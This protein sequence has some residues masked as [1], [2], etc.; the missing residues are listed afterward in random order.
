MERL[1]LEYLRPQSAR[2]YNFYSIPKLLI[3]HPG[4][5]EL[6]YGAKLLYGLILNRASLSAEH[7]EEFTDCQGRLYI[8]YTVEQVME[9]I[10]CARATA[11]KL[12]K[13]LTEIGLIE[14]KRQGQGK[15]TLIY[16]KDFASVNLNAEA[17]APAT[18]GEEEKSP[19]DQFPNDS[20]E[21]RREA[22][23]N[24]RSSNVE[25]Q[26]VQDV[27]FKKFKSY[28]SRSSSSRLLE[29]QDL[30][31]SYNDLND[32]DLSELKSIYLSAGTEVDMM[33]EDGLEAL[34]QNVEEQLEYPVLSVEYGEERAKE[35]VRLVVEVLCCEGEV[36]VGKGRYPPVLVRK[37]MKQLTCEHVRYALDSMAAGDKPVRNPRGYL[38]ASL[39]NAPVSWD[40]AETIR[41]EQGLRRWAG[42]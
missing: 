18:N 9:D 36:Q 32:L 38:L 33:D 3:D 31:S 37:R 28:T 8:V 4:F 39:F 16:V 41:A 21:N 12:L 26:E 27:D 19:E 15:P 17:A 5:D 23:E 35:I 10:R 7:S 24:S 6:D 22:T 34:T 42:R 14:K 11:V 2:R 25:L 1:N 13:Q 20:S 29:V 30:N 40:T